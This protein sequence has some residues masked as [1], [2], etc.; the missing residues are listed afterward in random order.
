MLHVN[1][2]YDLT[3]QLAYLNNQGLSALQIGQHAGIR[4][5]SELMEVYPQG[6]RTAKL[7]DNSS[8]DILKTGSDGDTTKASGIL[9]RHLLEL[10]ITAAVGQIKSV[11]ATQK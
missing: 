2:Y 9:G 1:R 5:T 11:M 4:D 3:Q 10:K 7:V 6:I 8:A